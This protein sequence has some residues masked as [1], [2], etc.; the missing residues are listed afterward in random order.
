MMKFTIHGR[1]ANLNDY[2]NACRTNRIKGN[3]IRRENQDICVWEIKSQLKRIHI[4]KP[5]ILHFAWYER[6]RKRD[7]DNVSSFGRKVIQDAL[8]E[9]GILK[10]DGW[11]YI[12]G[13]TDEFYIDNRNPRIE[14]EIEVVE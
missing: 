5:V 1:L 9:C 10:D 12:V 13:F 14:V 11:D 6:N 7:H 2:V 3:R 8:V 4:D